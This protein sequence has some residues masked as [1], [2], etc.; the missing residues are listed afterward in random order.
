MVPVGAVTIPEAAAARGELQ[1]V[2]YLAEEPEE[3][4]PNCSLAWPRGSQP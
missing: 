3:A 2:S 1:V 4:I